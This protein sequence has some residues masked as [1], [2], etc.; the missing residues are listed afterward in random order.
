MNL[1]NLILHCITIH[2]CNSC[3]TGT[4]ALPDMYVRCPRVSA[5]I[6]GKAR[7]PVFQLICYT[8]STPK[9]CPNH[10]TT[11]LTLYIRAHSH[12]DWDLYLNIVMTFIYKVH[13]SSFDCGIVLL[14]IH[15]KV[16]TR[17]LPLRNGIL[18]YSARVLTQKLPFRNGNGDDTVNIL[19]HSNL[20]FNVPLSH[21][22]SKETT[23]QYI[24]YSLFTR[25]L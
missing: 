7:V 19:L 13:C 22:R 16:L 1:I 25:A 9:I 21:L 5:N 6:S 14:K 10:L 12:Y 23:G 11:V 17:K 20:Y 18:L 15:A 24:S 3:N 8:S 4:S 2:T